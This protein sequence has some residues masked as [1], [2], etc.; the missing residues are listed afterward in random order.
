MSKVII[1]PWKGH[2]GVSWP[3][4]KSKKTLQEIAESGTPEGLPFRIVDESALPSDWTFF[5]AWTADFANPDGIG[6]Q[7]QKGNL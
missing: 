5:D 4:P 6:K 1:Y 7:K 3:N 2:L